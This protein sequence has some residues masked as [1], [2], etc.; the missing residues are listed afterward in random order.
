MDLRDPL[1]ELPEPVR[2][3]CCAPAEQ[4]PAAP[5][6]PNNPPGLTAI[7]YRIGTFTTF[8]RAMLDDVARP[9]L[10]LGLLDAVA[11]PANPFAERWHEGREG[12][13]HTQLVELWAYLADILTFYQER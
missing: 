2:E 5:L 6:R 13:F 10:L 4:P 9:D 7:Q 8:R 12:D 3:D 11:M 1:C